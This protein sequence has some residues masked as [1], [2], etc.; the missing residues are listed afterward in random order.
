ML[1]L[2]KATGLLLYFLYMPLEFLK[3]LFKGIVKS[4]LTY[5]F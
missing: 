2:N 5:F 3:S 1:L 4:N